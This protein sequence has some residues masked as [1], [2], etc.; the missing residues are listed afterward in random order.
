MDDISNPKVMRDTAMQILKLRE[1]NRALSLASRTPEPNHRQQ[2]NIFGAST[3]E[4]SIT[5]YPGNRM[6]NKTIK[7]NL[8]FFREPTVYKDGHPVKRVPG[9]LE[10]L[11]G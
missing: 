10:V 5:P 6:I 8:C 3:K 7:R 2:T 1:F 4:D 9:S 11:E